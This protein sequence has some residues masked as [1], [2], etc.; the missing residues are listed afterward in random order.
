MFVENYCIQNKINIG[1]TESFPLRAQ[2][3]QPMILEI[4][5]V[6][7]TQASQ[8]PSISMTGVQNL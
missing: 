2:L 4:T 5:K 7:V 3:K 1:N 8:C 6:G